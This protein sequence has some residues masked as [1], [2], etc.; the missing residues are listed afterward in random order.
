MQIEEMSTG[1][2][3]MRQTAYK[4]MTEALD[5]LPLVE[6]QVLSPLPSRVVPSDRSIGRS[7]TAE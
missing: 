7:D 3:E 6:L 1:E 2:L 4:A 5:Q